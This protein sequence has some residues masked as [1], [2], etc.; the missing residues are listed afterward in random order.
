MKLTALMQNRTALAGSAI[1]ALFIVVIIVGPMISPWGVDKHD[2]LSVL[3]PPSWEHPFGTDSLGRDVLTRALAGARVSLMISASGVLAA[4]ALGITT[5]LFAGYL[6]GWFDAVVM[7]VVDLF[8]AF[9]AFVLALFLM[10]ALGYGVVNVAL[11]IMLVYMPIFARLT[12]NTTEVVRDDAYVQAARI[13]G[14]GTPRILFRE[15][16]P[17]ISAPIMVQA[18][19]AVAFGIIIESGLSFIGLGVQPPTPS[20]GVIMADGQEYFRRAP[21]VLTMTGLTVTTALLAL[22]LLGDGLRDLADPRL[23]ARDS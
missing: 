23:K 15:I 17:N 3:K 9:P 22:N 6:G 19:I 2:F 16:L 5:G 11:A 10:V 7:R 20:L 18:S 14:Q 12:R 8:F 21:W 1:T 4:M 13:M